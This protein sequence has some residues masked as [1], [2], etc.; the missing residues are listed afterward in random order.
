MLPSTA[1]AVI[2]GGGVMG[3]SSAYHLA[4]RGAKNVVLL[5]QHE[6]LGAEATGKCA[7]GIRY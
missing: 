3:A 7:G 6:F 5:E 1:D 4:A 2:I